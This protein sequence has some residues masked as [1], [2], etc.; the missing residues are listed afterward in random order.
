[1]ALAAA[2]PVSAGTQSFY[3]VNNNAQPGM[4]MSLTANAKV[5]QPSTAQ[6]IRSFVGLVA[7]PNDATLNQQPGQVSLNT[8]GVANALVSTVNGNISTGDRITTSTIAGIGAKM[9]G[10][11]WIIGTAQGSLNAHSPGAVQTTVKS[12]QGANQS[13][14]VGSIPVIIKALYYT[15]PGNSTSQSTW[16]PASLQQAA[17]SIAGKHVSTLA[18]ITS[19]IV[20]VVGIFLA[21][22]IINSAVRGGMLAISRQP[23]SK[24]T[25]E[26]KIIQSFGLALIILVFMLA[27][28]W[29]LL[30]VA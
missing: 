7:G 23:L 14:Y 15:A 8:D 17:N 22:L 11:G 30:R 24:L 27:G 4:L 13:I 25:I 20:L 18:L 26:R 21:T 12:S 6:T 10:S 9:V 1:M 28:A 19:F 3:A 16:I 29:L 5:V 2:L